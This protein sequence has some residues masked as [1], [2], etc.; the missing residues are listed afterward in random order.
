LLACLILA[1]TLVAAFESVAQ[2]LI[3]TLITSCQSLKQLLHV[4]RLGRSR[5]D[6]S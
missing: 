6:E 1:A 2:R 5:T 4:R 3:L